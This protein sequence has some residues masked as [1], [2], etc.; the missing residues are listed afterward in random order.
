MEGSL[1][2]LAATSQRP[3]DFRSHQILKRYDEVRLRA[4]FLSFDFDQRRAYFGGGMSDQS[5]GDYCASMDWDHTTV[6]ARSGPIHLEAVAIL[7]SLPPAHTSVEL[8]IACLPVGDHERIVA[9]LLATS[10]DVAAL[11]HRTLIVN[12]EFANPDLPALLREN[13]AAHFRCETIE[14][15]LALRS[16]R[17][18]QIG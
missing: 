10:L 5:I 14:I 3:P 16:Q 2:R 7:I 18:T 9:E 8:S 12:R 4:F 13:P 6:I 15:D 11:R 1:S 17:K